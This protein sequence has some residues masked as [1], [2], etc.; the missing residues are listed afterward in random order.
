MHEL[1]MLLGTLLNNQGIQEF[2]ERQRSN[3][4]RMMESVSADEVAVNSKVAHFWRLV[5]ENG[6][7]EPLE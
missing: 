4:R 1:C 2:K 6:N 7:L 3:Y 5:S